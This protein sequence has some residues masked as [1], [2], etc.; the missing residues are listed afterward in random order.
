MKISPAFFF[1][2]FLISC[3]STGEKLSIPAQGTKFNIDYN[4]CSD[5]DKYQIFIDFQKQNEG[6]VQWNLSESAGLG[7]IDGTIRAV[8]K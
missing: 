4:E 2:G 6:V 8:K 1:I 3:G 5:V 7:I